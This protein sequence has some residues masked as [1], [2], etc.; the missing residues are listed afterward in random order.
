MT[1]YNVLDL[2][3]G[4]G[5]FSQAFADSDRWD[6][7][8]VDIED[9]F[10]PDIT[11]DVMNLRPSD[12]AGQDFDVMLASP[13]CTDFSP[14]AWSHGKRFSRDGEPLTE[15]A[16]E[17]VALVYHTLGLVRA[18][19]PTYWFVENP[20]GALRWLIG[21][22]QGTVDQCAYDH[23]TKKPTDLWGDHPPMTYHRC[24]HNTH[25]RDG[26]TDFERG[27]SD[28]SDRAEMPQEL[29]DAIREACETA[30][31]GEVAEQATLGDGWEG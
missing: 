6:V 2:F 13:P 3:C 26:I 17:S 31:D 22:P 21:K 11:A 10:D 16:Q 1:D 19:R 14:V 25:T 4:L 23:Y 7:T 29:S 8:T 30:L 12:F 20:R 5:G 27:P 15:D 18:L 9:K 24:E 28:P